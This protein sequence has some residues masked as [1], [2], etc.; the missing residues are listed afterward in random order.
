MGARSPLWQRHNQ[1]YLKNSYSQSRNIP[2]IL[3]N[4]AGMISQLEEEKKYIGDGRR[5]FSLPAL[6]SL[7]SV[8]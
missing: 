4:V 3:V 7:C 5:L 2:S 6:T 1:D 8:T